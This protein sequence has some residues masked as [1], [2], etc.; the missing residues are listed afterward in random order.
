MDKLRMDEAFRKIVRP[1]VWDQGRLRNRESSDQALYLFTGDV[2]T[3]FLKTVTDSKII[4]R[5]LMIQQA[6]RDI[7]NY[8]SPRQQTT[9]M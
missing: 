2:G 9:T 3:G 6:C 4:E 1:P 7:A 5:F 8:E